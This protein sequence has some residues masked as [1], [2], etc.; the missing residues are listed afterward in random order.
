MSLD[1]KD[2]TGRIRAIEQTLGLSDCCSTPLNPYLAGKVT[3]LWHLKR[4]KGVQPWFRDSERDE[5][6]R[7]YNH[8]NTR[9]EAESDLHIWLFVFRD[10]D[11]ITVRPL[12]D[13]KILSGW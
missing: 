5:L 10:C 13:R 3:T 12:M 6:V 8:G 9:G 2:K 4:Q 7:L 1:L 11:E